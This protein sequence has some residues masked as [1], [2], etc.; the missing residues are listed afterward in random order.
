M[1]DLNREM[2]AVS[3]DLYSQAKTQQAHGRPEAGEEGAKHR[4]GGRKDV[5]GVIDADFEEVGGH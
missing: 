1:E 4:T 3:S 5:G 2:Q